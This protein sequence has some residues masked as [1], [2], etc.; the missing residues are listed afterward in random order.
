MLKKGKTLQFES[1]CI[2]LIQ[3]QQFQPANKP[4]VNQWNHRDLDM[5]SEYLNTEP[6]FLDATEGLHHPFLPYFSGHILMIDACTCTYKY[7]YSCMKQCS[8]HTEQQAEGK[9]KIYSISCYIF[10]L[11]QFSYFSSQ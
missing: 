11:I 10:N 2:F 9:L 5:M 6:I 7:L 4:E 3:R 1:T 8:Y